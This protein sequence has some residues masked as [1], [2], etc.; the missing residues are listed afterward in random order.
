MHLKTNSDWRWQLRQQRR[1]LKP[2]HQQQA[3]VALAKLL[4]KQDF[5]HT[6]HSLAGYLAYDGEISLSPFFDIAQKQGKRLFVPV[7]PEQADKPLRFVAYS[8]ALPVSY[9][10]YGIAEPKDKTTSISSAELDTVLMPMLGFDIQGNRLGMGAGYYDR[11]LAQKQ[12][13]QTLVAVAHHCQQV[14][15][16]KPDE[17]DIRP[18]FIVTDRQVFNYR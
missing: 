1:Q 12:P 4:L 6:S 2:L 14:S 8:T 5:F 13:G 11:T 7:V 10:R 17:W 18:H 16:L 15:E 3:A 9:N